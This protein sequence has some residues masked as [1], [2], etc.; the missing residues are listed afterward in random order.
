MPAAV[1]PHRV[2]ARLTREL[3]V[4][5][6]LGVDTHVL[7]EAGDATEALIEMRT[8]LQWARNGLEDLFVLLGVCLVDL[9]SG[10]DILLEIA[11]SVLP[12]LQTLGQKSSSLYVDPK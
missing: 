5:A 11:Y 3:K 1:S 8:L 9:L 7:K 10:R 2:S 12:R 4:A 6:Y